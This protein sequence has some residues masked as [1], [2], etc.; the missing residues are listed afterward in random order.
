[1]LAILR[2]LNLE[3]YI[4][5]TA[6]SPTPADSTKPTKDESDALDKWNEGDARAR[7]QIELAIG[8]A[9]MIHISGALTACAMWEQRNRKGS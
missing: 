7:T 9:E 6:T 8:D 4:E 1:M 5:K 3:K 2:D